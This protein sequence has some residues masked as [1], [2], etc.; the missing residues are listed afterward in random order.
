MSD[1]DRPEDQDGLSCPERDAM[2]ATLLGITPDRLRT[3][4]RVH[5][6]RAG[7]AKPGRS[8]PPAQ[9]QRIDQLS[10]DALFATF[11]RR[12][13]RARAVALAGIASPI[14]RLPRRNVGRR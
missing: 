8:G 5:R 10:D 9:W 2:V 13:V 14:D 12:E 1:A 11:R 4:R 3:I 7:S 6:K